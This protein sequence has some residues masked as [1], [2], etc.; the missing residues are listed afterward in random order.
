[1]LFVACVVE[2]GRIIYS[3]VF[4]RNTGTLT[5]A[6]PQSGFAMKQSSSREARPELL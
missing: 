2:Q 4:K 5:R 1:M 6:G 3:I